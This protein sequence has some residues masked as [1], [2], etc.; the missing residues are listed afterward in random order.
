MGRE[1]REWMR[2]GGEVNK[3][4]RRLK[5]NQSPKCII[6]SAVPLPC[7]FNIVKSQKGSR[8]VVP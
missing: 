4:E 3:R 2:R 6:W 1:R 8:A 7:Y 5:E